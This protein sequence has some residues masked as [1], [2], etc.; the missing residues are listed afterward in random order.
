VEKLPDVK[1]VSNFSTQ[2]LAELQVKGKHIDMDYAVVDLQRLQAQG[3]M[4]QLKKKPAD[5]SLIISERFAKQNDLKVGQNV[6]VGEFSNATQ[7]VE[8]K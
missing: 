5:N 1:S 6:Q 4:S 2:G 3:L 7:A 8:P